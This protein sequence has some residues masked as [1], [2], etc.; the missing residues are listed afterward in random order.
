MHIGKRLKALMEKRGVSPSAM[1]T[2][3]EIS[4]GAVSNWFVS[5]RISK[6]NLSKAAEKLRT[7]SDRLVNYDVDEILEMEQS[8][9]RGLPSR[10]HIAD[11]VAGARLH[12]ERRQYTPDALEIAF[13]YDQLP[14]DVAKR[15]ATAFVENLLVK[16]PMLVAPLPAP[17]VSRTRASRP[18]QPSAPP[19]PKLR[20]KNRT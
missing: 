17:A 4:R 12:L 13:L 8:D 16:N 18:R 11:G 2:H 6:E 5:G 10:Q 19:K 1:A 3:C 15:R 7:T 9:G 20:P 14:T